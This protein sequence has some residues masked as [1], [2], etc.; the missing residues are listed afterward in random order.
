MELLKNLYEIY[1]PSNGEKKLK[2]FIKRWVRDNVEDA[3]IRTDNNDGNVY[4]MRGES[5]TYPCVVA[6]LDQ[7]QRNHS[8]DFKA[9]ETEDIIFGY[10]PSKRCREGLGA[11]DK[12]GIWIA[13]QCLQE[14]DVIKVAFFVGEEIGCIGSGRCDMSYF[15]DCR[16]II[17]PDRRGCSDLITS[18]SG[19]ICSKEFE[20][21]LHADWFGYA[22]TSG[23]MTDVLELSERGVGLS[24]INLS[25][26]YFDPHSDDEYTVKSD[27]YNCLAL[28]RHAI[29]TITDVYPHEYEYSYGSYY[30]YS[31]G[32]YGSSRSSYS[33]SDYFKK[34][35]GDDDSDNKKKST[36]YDVPKIVY[37][38]EFADLESWVDQL[39]YQ[40]YRFYNP[41]ELWPYV[42]SD[43]ATYE[44]T[45]ETFMELAW[46]YYEYYVD[47]HRYYEDDNDWSWDATRN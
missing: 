34:W 7:V 19:R 17:E 40:N 15:K 46:D 45:E 5:D 42:E 13:L 14:F 30:G 39:M 47:I 6:H 24:C 21:A 38:S 9:V 29:T 12:N 1:A 20:E 28:V 18:I 32:G 41:E 35:Y 31:Y 2:K 27:L 8:S 3:I 22:P 10:S 33:G 36:L 11:D 26:G 16:F 4:I 23:M 43:L 25:C 44:I 37:I